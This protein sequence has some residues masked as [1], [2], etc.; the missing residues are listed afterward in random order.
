MRCLCVVLVKLYIPYIVICCDVCVLLFCS[1]VTCAAL[2]APGNGSMSV[3]NGGVYPS[4]AT[5]SCNAGYQLSG[6]STLTCLTNATWSAPV[7]SCVP[8]A[9]PNLIA[10]AHSSLQVSGLPP[11]VATVTC[12]PGYQASGSTSLTCLAS[13]TWS[14]ALP[15]CN[16][17]LPPA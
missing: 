14:S 17:M 11:Y 9:C 16:G 10:P 4:T 5:F 1:G 12:D 3:S 2:V 6:L 15:S 13:A 7:P 8:I